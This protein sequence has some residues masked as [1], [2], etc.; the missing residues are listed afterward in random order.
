LEIF[1][2]VPGWAVVLLGLLAAVILIVLNFGWLLAAK[3]MLTRQRHTGSPS[4]EATPAE[5]AE[6]TRGLSRRG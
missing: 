5:H 3:G 2:N 4:G 6:P 1:G